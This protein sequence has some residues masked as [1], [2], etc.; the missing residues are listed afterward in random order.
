MAISGA[1]LSL[2]TSSVLP[3]FAAAKVTPQGVD[4]HCR[5]LTAYARSLAGRAARRIFGDMSNDVLPRPG[6]GRGQWR[7]FKTDADL[8]AS[9]TARGSTINSVAHVWTRNATKL[10]TIRF[11]SDAGDWVHDVEYCFRRDGTLAR[12]KSTLETP[13]TDDVKAGIRR[14]RVRYY[15]ATGRPLHA[16]ARVVEPGGKAPSPNR[17]FVDQDEP[18]YPSVASLPFGALR[19]P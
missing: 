2:V 16:S 9:A 12:S 3:A 5:T 10:V 4:E 1:V 7:Q 18:V 17:R 6:T 11:T 8:Q 14:V 13:S 19:Q 15:D